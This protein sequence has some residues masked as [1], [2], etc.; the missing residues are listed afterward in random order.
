[1]NETA[2][3]KHPFTI[4]DR[5]QFKK[6]LTKKAVVMFFTYFIVVFFAII[7]A[8]IVKKGF[9]VVFPGFS[10]KGAPL[11]D[12]EFFTKMP[13]TLVAYEDENGVSHRK[14]IAE[15]RDFTESN[16]DAVIRKE[17]RY[18]Y[19][20]GGILG[21]LVGTILLV[22]ICIVVAL[23]IGIASAIYL[24]EY[25]SQ[26]PLMRL[27]RLAMLNLAG[28]PSI[29]YGLF[30]LGFFCYA[31]PIFTTEVADR[32]IFYFQLPGTSTFFSLQGFGTSMTAGGLTLAAMILPVIITACE[33]SLKA[34]PMGFREASLALGATK[35]ETIRKAVL[36]YA[37]PGMLT[38]SVLGITR[39][40]GE[41]AP[42]MFTAAAAHKD[43]LPWQNLNGGIAA[44]PEFFT[45]SVQA[46]PYHIYTVAAR[47]PQSE[48]T[49]PMQYGSVFVFMFAVMLLAALSIYLRVRARKALKW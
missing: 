14:D 46:L 3:S 27:V 40:A 2:D 21:P 4:P 41:T 34:V 25:S 33:E 28:V 7:F 18:S 44:I 1:M 5:K 42:I 12:A 30:G 47:I 32:S 24:S 17:H 39:V 6:D 13:G 20:G 19:S 16:P 29:V 37:L 35:W 9:P 26:G 49:K 36:P 48:Y 43:Q 15:F 31:F 22:V 10:E 23:I 45:Q 11:F 38:A 8:D